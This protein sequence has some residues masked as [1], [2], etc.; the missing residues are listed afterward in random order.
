MNFPVE[1]QLFLRSR[2]AC[3]SILAVLFCV[4]SLAQGVNQASGPAQVPAPL[5]STGNASTPTTHTPNAGTPAAPAQ[6]T[7]RDSAPA[8]QTAQPALVTLKQGV[9]QVQAEDSDL[10]QIL[11]EIADRGGMTIDG[12]V[13]SVRV[14]G[15]YGPGKSRDVLT[16][17]LTGLGYNFMMVGTT[18]RGVP[19]K[20]LLTDRINRP[21]APAVAAPPAPAAAEDDQP[22]PGAVVNVPPAGPDDPQERAQQNLQRLQQMHDQQTKPNE[23]Q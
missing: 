4:H 19:Q 15:K 6:S 17:L 9:L 14:Y 18:Q 12:S 1:K 7:G 22:G 20:L 3:I 23:P 5:S 11:R 2:L 8:A 16:D 13:P 21:S 10:H